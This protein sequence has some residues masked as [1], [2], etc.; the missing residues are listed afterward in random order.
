METQT[1]EELLPIVKPLFSGNKGIQLV[2]SD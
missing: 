2:S 1:F